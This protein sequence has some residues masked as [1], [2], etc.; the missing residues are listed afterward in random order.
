MLLG[1]KIN[2]IPSPESSVEFEYFDILMV[3]MVVIEAGHANTGWWYNT[4]PTLSSGGSG[5]PGN[6]SDVRLRWPLYA[7]TAP[8][9]IRPPL[10]ELSG[11][12]VGKGRDQ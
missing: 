8:V 3:K 6:G 4:R 7:V 5:E 10:L 12:N 11:L 1:A 9:Q 2:V